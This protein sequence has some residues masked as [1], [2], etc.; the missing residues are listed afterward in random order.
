MKKPLLIVIIILAVILFLPAASFLS[1]TFQAKKPMNVVV[2]DKTVPNLE[3]ENHKSFMWI[4][5]NER[6]VKKEK[7]T[8][9]SFRKDYYGFFPKR[10]L[11]SKDYEKKDFP[12]ITDVFAFV[13]SCDALY[14]TDSY[15]VYMNDWYRGISTSRR[16]RKL[17][18]GLTNRDYIYFVE[19]QRKNK[20]CIL[21]YNTFDYPT[22]E[23]ERY[24]ITERLG[25]SFGGWSG[26][27]FS[28]LDTTDKSNIDFPIWMT[29]LY[30]K[31]YRMPWNFTRPGIVFLKNN[32]IIVLEEGTHLKKA[33]PLVVTD[34]AYAT[35]YKLENNVPFT[36]WFDVI[37]PL[38]SKVISNFKL[39]TTPLADSILADNLLSNQFPAVITDTTNQRT[40]YFAGDFASNKVPYWISRFNGIDRLKGILYSEK[41][42]DSRRFFWLYYKPLIN[43]IFGDY[44][45]TMNKK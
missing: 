7:K 3:K 31:T 39:E 21:E 41:P 45:E 22:P 26:K 4:L 13:D 35:R 12:S 17:Y 36:N 15:G 14:F 34:S 24:K 6:F 11:R 2:L 19:M 29:S 9:Y 43:G 37:D 8:S 20:L 38:S 25:I 32:E 16:S 1:W 23:L 33:M 42:E 5:T 27:Y 18:G 44:Y 40:Y 10:P 30:R 28:S